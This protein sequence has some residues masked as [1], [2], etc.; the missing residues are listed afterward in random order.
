MCLRVFFIISASFAHKTVC[1][2]DLAVSGV[3]CDFVG[4]E[5]RRERAV[6]GVNECTVFQGEEVSEGHR[7]D[8]VLL[9]Y[10]LILIASGR[11]ITLI[12]NCQVF[13]ERL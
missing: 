5:L 3:L 12:C 2:A 1:A 13:R 11:K 7:E 9:G 4:K 6:V 8:G 10:V